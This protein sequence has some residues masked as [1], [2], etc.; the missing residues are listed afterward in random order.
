[1]TAL[2]AD[3]NGVLA[4]EAEIN[5]ALSADPN[6]V[7]ALTARAALQA[8]RGDSVG[9]EATYRQ[10]LQRF[11]DFVPAQR[12]LA[13]ILVN[14]PTKR[15][16]AYDLATK[17]R[18]TISGDPLISIVLGRVSYERKDFSRAIQLF[19]ESAR[20]KP[21]DAKSLYYLG[22]AHAQAKHKAEAKET[23]NRALQAGLGDAEASEAKRALADIGGS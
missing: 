19:Q 8:K 6:Y 13:A 10:I 22:M 3:G 20:E 7:P 2:S 15:D 9:A 12:D 5:S 17:A 23:L 14:D 1:M 11:P 16:A 21:L 4:S 18:R